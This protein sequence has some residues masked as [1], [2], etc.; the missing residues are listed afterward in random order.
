MREREDSAMSSQISTSRRRLLV[1]S[2]ALCALPFGRALADSGCKGA[3]TNI[4]GPA[5]R[6][7]APFRS[8]LCPPDEPGTPLTLSG[9]VA[10][11][12]TCKPLS[13]V[14]LDIWQVDSKGEYDWNSSAFHLRGKFRAD[15]EGHYAFDT[16]MPVPYGSRPKHIHYLVTRDGYEPHI[17]QCYFDGD[18]RNAT[19]R[20]VKKDLIIAPTP[21]T[22]VARRPGALAGTFDI[23]MQREQPPGKNAETVYR[24]YS[25]DYLV[26][27]GV[28]LRVSKSGRHLR[29]HV[30][31]G[32][33][34]GDALDGVFEPR[35]QNR[36]FVP[37]YDF[38]VSFV[39]NEHGEVDHVLDSRGILMKKVHAD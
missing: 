35:A 5:Y 10:D 19:D 36:F 25:G 23:A 12:Q 26:A 33:S 21:Q 17:T 27:P 31:Q 30:N 37:E 1:G 16:I 28:T 8:S 18:E 14:V 32:E 39:R 3:T 34:D 6:K 38:D 13:G 24:E 9:T 2:I 22:S 4:L 20:Y 7:G 29:W 11:A 15:S